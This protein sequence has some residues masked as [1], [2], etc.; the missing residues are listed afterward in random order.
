MKRILFIVLGLVIAGSCGPSDGG[1]WDE[2]APKSRSVAR[3]LTAPVDTLVP[4]EVG[5]DGLA[6]GRTVG[7]PAVGPDGAANYTVPLWVPAGRAGMQPELALSYKSNGSNGPLGLGWSLSTQSRISRCARTQAQDGAV[8]GVT[9]T[10]ADAFCLDGE[11]LVA[12]SGTYGASATEYRTE[13][14]GFARIVSLESDASGP[15][16]FRVYLKN[17]R[18]LT[19]GK[20]NGSTFSGTRVRV[21][22]VPDTGFIT[23]VDGR[24]H[25]LQWAL[26]RVEDRSGNFIS[27]HY[28]LTHDAADASS[29][30]WLSR[31][32]YTESS[33]GAGMP[34]TRS[35][36]FLYEDRPDVGVLYVAGFKLKLSR[37]LKE[38][39]MH[40][41]NPSVVGRVRAY[42]FSYA[43]DGLSGLSLLS[44]LQECDGAGV[45]LRPL[46]FGWTPGSA[47]FEEVNTGF[48]DLVDRGSSSGDSYFW[49]LKPAD[50]DGD[51]R[52]D[53]LYRR[54]HLGSA[55]TFSWAARHA[56]A[57][58][59]GPA[60]EV[61][62]LPRICREVQSGHDGRWADVNLDGRVDVSILEWESCDGVYP[63]TRMDT[64]LGNDNPGGTDVNWFSFLDH[65]GQ[66]GGF[67][68][69]DLDGDALPELVRVRW[70]D[71]RGRLSFRPNVAGTLGAWQDIVTSDI[72]D[73]TQFVLD[74][75]GTGRT[76]LLMTEMRHGAGTYEVVGQR[77]W[78]VTLRNGAFEKQET[79]LVRT[80]VSNQQYLFA[81]I[82]GDAL[83]D[84]L[85]MAN[86]GGDL[87][88]L[89]NTGDGF[90]QP[91][92]VD[93]A[94]EFEFGSFQKE[95]GVRILD[96][97]R[98]GRQDLLLMDSRGGTRSQPVVLQSTGTGFAPRTLPLPVGRAMP[99]GYKLS[100]TL[101]ANGDGLMDLAQVVDGTLRIYLRKGPPSGLL[102]SVV[103][104]F[105]SR[106]EFSYKPMI[107]SAVYTPG[108]GCSHP[109]S[110]LRKGMW[111][112]SE[113]RTDA[114]DHG[115]RATQFRYEDGRVDLLG[116]GWLGFAAITA[117]DRLTGAEVR[118]ERDNR[119]RMGSFYP[120]AMLPS[121]ETTRL[122]DGGR[123]H[124]QLRSTRYAAV[125]R[126]GPQ[127][128][129][130]L[131]VLPESSWEE[132]HDRQESEPSMSGLLRRIETVWRYDGTYGNLTSKVQTI[133]GG[134]RSEWTAT[135][136]NDPTS[137][138]I[139]L[140]ETV[141]ETSTV[142]GTSVTR[143]KRYKYRPGTTLPEREVIEPGDPLLELTT[144]Y[145]RDADGLIA[146][147]TQTGVG[148]PSRTSNITYDTID[149]TYPT[150]VTNPLNHTIQLAYH[151][152]LGVLST[153]TDENG[154]LTRWQYDGFGRI[155]KEDGPDSADV[156]VRYMACSAGSPCAFQTLSFRAGGQEVV[157]T[158]DRLGR[159]LSTRQRGFSGEE[160]ITSNEY[161]ALGRRWKAWAPSPTGWKQVS[162]TFVH[163]ALG[164]VLQTIHPDGTRAVTRYEGRK[165]TSW[166]EKNNETV[167]WLDESGRPERSEDRNGA[168]TVVT[169]HEYGPFGLLKS[170]TNGY[171]QGPRF[172]YD[173]L[174]R[175]TRQ[176][177]PDS[178]VTVSRYNPFGELIEATD[179]NEDTSV[180]TRD[181]LGRLTAVRSRDGVSRFFWDG[182]LNG[183]GK[184]ERSVEEGNPLS[185]LDDIIVAHSYDA[186]GRPRA[187]VWNVEGT[188]YTLE[189]TYDV[190]GRPHRMTYPVVGH[191]QLA[192]E[193]EYT[194]WGELK[195]VRDVATGKA[196]WG[197]LGRNGRGQLTAE[198]FGNGV[199]SQR[200]FDLR[201]RT[202]FIDSK[203]GAQPLQL[204]AY[205]YEANGNLRSR[206][207][208][209]GGT[210]E[211]FAYDGLDRLTRWTAFQNCRS[212][213]VEY[214]YDDIGNLLGRSVLQGAGQSISYFYEGLGA[215]P[216]AVT[217]SSLGSYTYDGS[218][219]QRT[220]PGRTAEYTTF[221]LP[222]RISNGSQSVTF[223][224][225]AHQARTV[226]RSSNG[227]VTVYVGGLYEVRH[228]P[229]GTA[230]HG[231]HIVGADRPVAQVLWA[232][233]A[234]GA[235]TSQK[236]FYLH[237][238]PLGSVES[239]T[240]EAGAVVERMRYEPFGGRRYAHDL[241]APLR[242]DAA[243]VRQGFTGHEHDEE[244]GLI[245]MKGRI[246]DPELG[247]FL[248][249][250]PFI[251]APLF[252]QS[253]NRYSYVFNNP[254]RFTDP[255]GFVANTPII[256]YDSWYGGWTTMS[257][258]SGQAELF[259]PRFEFCDGLQGGGTVCVTAEPDPEST[260]E[261]LRL[262][263]QQEPSREFQRFVNS[264]LGGMGRTWGLTES[265]EGG[266]GVNNGHLLAGLVF[267]TVQAVV[268]LGFVVPSPASH[269]RDFEVG[270]GAGMVIVG[271]VQLAVGVGMGLTGSEIG[272]LGLVAA[273][274]SEGVSLLAV[275]VGIAISVAGVATA[276]AGAANIGVGAR[277]AYMAVQNGSGGGG[278]GPGVAVKRGPKTDPTAPH[279]A[280]IREVAGQVK[281]GEVIAGGGTRPERLIPTPDGMKTG[282]RPDILVQKPDG[283]RYG[284]NVGQKA[285]SGA[286][287]RRE[288]EAINDL[289]GAG[290]PMHFVPYGP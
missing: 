127:G 63:P 9:F 20:L 15:G 215:G 135:Y 87:E 38:L 224:Y 139:G 248:S 155:R 150:L 169:L 53:L 12:I 100:Q 264:M 57:T 175:R 276:T 243:K 185:S 183:V 134:D 77:Y 232:T 73:N 152:G 1:P 187:D 256:I 266:G 85:R 290:L 269:L 140:P 273:P 50:V 147:V 8:E 32:D 119:T 167:V 109:Q 156:A 76:S 212:S 5:S 17:G 189:Q 151:G 19:Y 93:L 90:A 249:P 184:L 284:I 202:L 263:G 236:T 234:S 261:L 221:G 207:D 101:D 70:V 279:N 170:I 33:V 277:T 159:P 67:W 35:V 110:C 62:T 95:N 259:A 252:S 287:V 130:L 46:S 171:G 226:K 28:T 219:N 22:P 286:P 128:G 198:V 44:S 81:D 257:S 214:S 102:S 52:D 200:R 117:R 13:R 55:G 162:T 213:V 201:S 241:T 268:P 51:G 258:S 65:D 42:Q 7:A 105:G 229:A 66:G 18:I 54:P 6:A 24:E 165:V 14:D 25:R 174:G 129:K 26:A 149:R 61:S 216:H 36:E 244:F 112:V 166:D 41:P 106:V 34:A 260:R 163:D 107:D 206:H 74:L 136:L 247:R 132:I 154:L 83:P 255:T 230:T 228:S 39:R 148:A 84:A 30:H 11:R 225:D 178:G 143:T 29:E 124:Q 125:L 91:F 157:S 194:P 188:L 160:V 104:G 180:Y 209:L 172:Q 120:H 239:I 238:D 146:Q 253:L 122:V 97:N 111:L 161:D 190:Y 137:W 245:N 289:E 197:A 265:S 145:A 270:R 271:L 199:E 153:R 68:H 144:S 71:G 82:N 173:R 78:A 240:D 89:M 43:T 283:S 49:I 45:C 186:L 131:T 233:D 204:L 176:E 242:R 254:L 179:G 58:G 193:H 47:E 40:A 168:K 86:T 210:T 158:L 31:I 217:R 56:S 113:L 280:K 211:D 235:I 27:F 195:A 267:G 48:T 72:N 69:A 227:E 237:T 96:F 88:V 181:V 164:R 37:R 116:R 141:Q 114:G 288:A 64:F 94:P 196:Y 231:F 121:T 142:D 262:H 272:G 223:R 4:T 251:Q 80:D 108:T 98:D 250:D 21:R 246:Y 79:T 274:F 285:A 281:D 177:D 138:L 103:D 60:A 222:S 126:D 192:V 275:P 118:T 133:T 208:R 218:G 16:L 205:E 182:A 3:R 10:S 115:L 99:A 75:D 203:A 23:T 59:Y 2:E 123:L 220:A 92:T 282:R 191:R 278:A